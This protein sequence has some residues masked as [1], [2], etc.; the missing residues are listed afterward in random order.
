MYQCK[1]C[2]FVSKYKWN[3]TRHYNRLHSIGVERTHHP[4]PP[5]SESIER[6]QH[7]NDNEHHSYPSNVSVE[8][9]QHQ[10]VN[11]FPSQSIN[12]SNNIN[13]P[14]ITKQ[15]I[16][17]TAPAPV[18][19]KKP[20]ITE[21]DNHYFDIRLKA[22]FKILFSGPSRSGKTQFLKSIIENLD[23]FSKSPPRKKILIYTVMQPI[24]HQ[25]GVDVLVRD[26]PNLKEEIFSISGGENTLCI[27]DDMINS[28]NLKE[29]SE[30][31]LVDG[32]HKNLSQIFITQQLFVNNAYF[33]SISQNSDYY[34]IFKN[35]RN[36][37]EIGHLAT[38][39]TP[40]NRE[41][42]KYFQLAT[43]NAF[44]YLF[45]NLT[46]ECDQRVK[47]L[48]NLFSTPNTV[49]VYN[50]NKERK[51][52][53]TENGKRTCFKHM[54]LKY[55]DAFYPY[56]QTVD[57]PGTEVSTQT[58]GTE[59]STQTPGAEVST[60]SP[61]AEVSTQTPGTEVSTQTPGTEVS[62]QI[63]PSQPSEMQRLVPSPIRTQIVPSQSS[64]IVPLQPSEIVPSQPSELQRLVPSTMSTQ[65]VPSQPSEIQ[66][67]VPPTISTQIVRPQP[68]E[69]Q[70]WVP[71]KFPEE[72]GNDSIRKD[73]MKRGRESS[74]IDTE[75]MVTDDA[76]TKRFR[77]DD[78]I[79]KKPYK[80]YLKE[81][82]FKCKICLIRMR[83]EKGLNKHMKTIHQSKRYESYLRGKCFLCKSVTHK[84]D[85]ILRGPDPRPIVVYAC[86]YCGIQRNSERALRS[87]VRAMHDKST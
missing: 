52:K 50:E 74:G 71:S 42:V 77:N 86:T 1:Y 63:V 69:M 47:Y 61:G 33:R 8:R 9:T 40:G 22:N 85:C 43:R 48:S 67:L 79:V 6:T 4:P 68:S 73:V 17:I 23:I 57:T 55:D 51:L 54:I 80:S 76:L 75:N 10:N 84:N 29:V 16:N 3:V 30:L 70:G 19:Y 58:P 81:F 38:Q 78:D 12:L 28:G 53:D 36:A 46:Q 11:G 45:I 14:P 34:I 13:T 64:E 27:F 2:N 35:P 21:N 39:M 83:S 62:T 56:Q 72:E 49:T 66:R 7:Q 65:I 18:E 82:R 37:A 59:V 20:V 5:N 41:L 26:S 60:Q 44:S 87:H 31:F 32:R 15:I 24:Y 25:L